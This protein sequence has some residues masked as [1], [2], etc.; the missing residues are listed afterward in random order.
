MNSKQ[1]LLSAID[2]TLALLGE[3]HQ[4][5]DDKPPPKEPLPSLLNRC[6]DACTILDAQDQTPVRVIHHLACTG[7]TL[8]SRCIEAMPNTVLLSEIDPLSPFPLRKI[9]F[10]PYD[11]I[12]QSQ[13]SLRPLD[14]TGVIETFLAGLEAMSASHARMGR[15]LV[16]R[17]HTHSHFCADTDPEDRP[18]IGDIIQARFPL[19]SLITV[20]HPLDSFLSLRNNGWIHF[21]PDTLDEYC[22]RY[23]LFLDAYKD[24]PILRY[25]DFIADQ[26]SGARLIAELLDLSFTIHW[27]DLLSVIEVSGDSG[28]KSDTIELRPRR[29][30]S[31]DLLRE[32]DESHCYDTL[33]GRLDYNRVAE[34][35]PVRT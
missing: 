16:I 1:K 18:T 7:G 3:T 4:S 19:R 12:R 29:E 27:R 10:A 20:R 26:D 28:R 13:T 8:L 31:V 15:R 11:L 6:E 23:N 17:D 33:C 24:A 30:V 21:Q 14:E 32:I 2:E 9:D 22:R 25:E 5:A 35:A 34:E